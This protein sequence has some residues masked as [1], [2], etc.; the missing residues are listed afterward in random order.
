LSRHYKHTA[1]LSHI[2]MPEFK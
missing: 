1:Q 2:A